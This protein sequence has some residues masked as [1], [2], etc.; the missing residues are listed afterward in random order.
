M[1]RVINEQILIGL[2]LNESRSARLTSIPSGPFPD[3]IDGVTSQLDED[4]MIR[5]LL[6][7]GSPE[8]VRSAHSR[9]AALVERVAGQRRPRA[10]QECKL[11]QV[12]LP[13]CGG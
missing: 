7:E 8:S 3:G 13:G 5:L 10:L 12:S 4:S 6:A 11:L 9:A 2:P 1:A